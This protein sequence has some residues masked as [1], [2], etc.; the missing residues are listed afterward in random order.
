MKRGVTNGHTQGEEEGDRWILY[1][2]ETQLLSPFPTF[3]QSKRDLSLSLSLSV[4]LYSIMAAA[5][6][7]QRS[8]AGGERSDEGK[9]GW[10]WGE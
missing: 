8:T 5:V 3:W 6:V 1:N 7:V 4:S 9:E 10:V 2:S